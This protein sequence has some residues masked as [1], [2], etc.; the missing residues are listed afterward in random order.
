MK[1]YI[2]G[3]HGKGYM[4]TVGSVFI[5]GLD[6]YAVEPPMADGVLHR[7]SLSCDW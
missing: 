6:T 1:D 4:K 5:S 3:D 2:I 7:R